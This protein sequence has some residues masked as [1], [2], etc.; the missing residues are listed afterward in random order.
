MTWQ[1]DGAKVHRTRKILTYLDGQFGSRM[2]AMD[3]IQ[4]HDYPARSP[5][6]NPLYFFFA[7]V[8]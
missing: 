8:F 3:I 6:L 4:G 2:L 5:D 7:W 1:Q